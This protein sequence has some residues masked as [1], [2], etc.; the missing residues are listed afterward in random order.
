MERRNRV[1]QGGNLFLAQYSPRCFNLGKQ[2][3]GDSV[4]LSM[5]FILS[6]NKEEMRK[7]LSLID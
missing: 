2:I 5:K 3:W 1:D 7:N 4:V 6:G